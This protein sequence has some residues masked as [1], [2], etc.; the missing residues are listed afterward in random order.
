MIHR[1]I[2]VHKIA[3]IYTSVADFIRL[4]VGSGGVNIFFIKNVIYKYLPT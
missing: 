4:L 3:V 2:F 1:S